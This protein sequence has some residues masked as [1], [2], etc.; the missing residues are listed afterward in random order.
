MVSTANQQ[1]REYP[2]LRSLAETIGNKTV[3][4]STASMAI[5]REI[6]TVLRKADLYAGAVDGIPGERTIIAFG[7]FKSINWL[8]NPTL[9]GRSTIL[10]LLEEKHPISEQPS[11][12]NP[13]AQPIRNLGSRTGASMKLP[14]GDL[15]YANQEIIAGCS[16]TWGEFT[17]NC[18]RIPESNQIVQ[19]ALKFAAVF[20]WIRDKWGRP[21]GLTSGYRPPA[22]NRAI[23][24]A[25]FSRH[26]NGDAGDIYPVGGSIHDLL[27]VVKSSNA[28]GIGLG[29]HKGFIHVDC[30]PS[31]RVIFNY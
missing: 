12:V 2:I 29:M 31:I 27:N 24:G 7:K 4:I 28:S 18:T 15:I 13:V 30:R 16:L 3:E 25:R 1:I 17:K 11:G 19:G 5:T 14:N 6:Q 9:L 22:V 23:G 26:M 8:E 20:G 10:A 21:I